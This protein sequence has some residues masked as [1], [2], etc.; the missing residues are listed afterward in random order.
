MRRQS[1][2]DLNRTQVNIDQKNFKTINNSLETI[3]HS[4]LDSVL[5]RLA[6]LEEKSQNLEQ[7]LRCNT[8]LV[9]LN[10]DEKR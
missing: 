6:I 4:A 5:H 1:V 3:S 10:K 2:N 7:T 9:N 8:S